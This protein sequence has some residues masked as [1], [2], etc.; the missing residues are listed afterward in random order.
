MPTHLK[1]VAVVIALLLG[2]GV[3]AAGTVSRTNSY[4]AADAE[5]DTFAGPDPTTAYDPW[6]DIT[7]TGA[8]VVVLSHCVWPT[9][10]VRLEVWSTSTAPVAWVFNVTSTTG[11]SYG[12]SYAAV[13]PGLNGFVVSCNGTNLR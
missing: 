5:V 9:E 4:E 3:F 1:P 13:P 10:P 8:R 2:A 6:T 12:Q 11:R 7:E